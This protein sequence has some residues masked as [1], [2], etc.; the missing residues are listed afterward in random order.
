MT[1]FEFKNCIDKKQQLIEWTEEVESAYNSFVIN[2]AYS[3]N[4]GT[5]L[6]AAELNKYPLMPNKQQFHF[7][8]FGL[9]KGNRFDK[10]IKKDEL[11]QDVE[12]LQK[13]YDINTREA[14]RM[15]SLLSQQ[16]LSEIRSITRKGGRS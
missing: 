9:P 5:I 1:P 7:Y 10:W 8:Y 3:F 4:V 16:Q 15:L 6:F 14:E 2:R 11:H 12:M 13:Y